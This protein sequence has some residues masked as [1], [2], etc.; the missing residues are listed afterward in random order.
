MRVVVKK[1][2][3]CAVVRLPAAVMKSANRLAA[4]FG[5][6]RSLRVRLLPSGPADYSSPSW[7]L[8][9]KRSAPSRSICCAA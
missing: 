6:V 8:A 1:W 5:S 2:G 4:S 3:N 7:V 9:R